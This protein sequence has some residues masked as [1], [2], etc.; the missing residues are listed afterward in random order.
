MKKI[1]ITLVTMLT[2]TASWAFTGEEAINKQALQAFKTE[3]AGASDAAWSSD[4]DYYKVSFTLIDQKLFAYYSTNGEFIAV[5]RYLSSTQLP[6]NLQISLKKY[7]NKYWLT[8]LFE[9]ASKRG[10]S[11]YVTLET[12]DTKIILKSVNGRDWSVYQK[13]KKA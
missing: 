11:Y 6:L 12:A 10:S 8:D 4:D 9:L 7:Y 2:L 5:T 13:D 3:F 1:M